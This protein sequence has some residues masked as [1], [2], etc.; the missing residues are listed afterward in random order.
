MCLGAVPWSGVRSLL[1]G[2]RGEDAEEIGFDEGTKPDRWVRSLEK[3]GIV[4]TRDVL[5]R[6]AASVL[7]EYARRG[8]EIYN[9][10]QDSGRL[11]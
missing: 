10:R 11:S 6:E 2:A 7:R 5:R 3:R 8:G 4:V 9:P 1:C